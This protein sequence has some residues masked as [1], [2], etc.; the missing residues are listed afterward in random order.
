MEEVHKFN[1][2]RCD[3]PS[4]GPSRIVSELVFVDQENVCLRNIDTWQNTQLLLISTY[5]Y[6]LGYI[7]Q[8][9]VTPILNDISKQNWRPAQTNI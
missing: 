3:I 5:L 9:Y 6:G 7:Q 2:F 4:S 1:E 8:L